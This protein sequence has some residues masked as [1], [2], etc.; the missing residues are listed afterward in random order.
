[1]VFMMHEA[2]SVNAQSIKYLNDPFFEQWLIEEKS[3]DNV[4]KQPLVAE[5]KLKM[6]SNTILTFLMS[7]LPLEV[8]FHFLHPWTFC[9]KRVTQIL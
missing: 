6:V 5:L 3:E 1:M 8:T 2:K 4:E 7:G 9:Q